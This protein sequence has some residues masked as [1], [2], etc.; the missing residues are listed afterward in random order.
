MF[1][2]ERVVEFLRVF[3]F[4]VVFCGTVC[5][6]EGGDGGGEARGKRG[7]EPS[8]GGPHWKTRKLGPAFRTLAQVESSRLLLS[9]PDSCAMRA[10]PHSEASAWHKDYAHSAYIFVKHLDQRLSEGDLITILSQFGTVTDVHMPRDKET[11]KTKGFAFA[12]Y[13]DQRSTVLAVDNF[14]KTKI[15]GKNILCDH[16]NDYKQEQQKDP[17]QIPQNLR[18]NLSQQQMEQ[19]KRQIS[20]RNEEITRQ[21]ELKAEIFSYA[22]GT[23]ETDDQRIEKEVRSE[24]IYAKEQEANCKRLAHFEKTQ[25]KH[26]MDMHQLNERVN[27]QDVSERLGRSVSPPNRPAGVPERR[28]DAASSRA[29]VGYEWG[30]RGGAVEVSDDSWSRFMGGGGKRKKFKTKLQG[31]GGEGE[32][33]K[34]QSEEGGGGLDEANT[35]RA[36]LGL[37]P[38]RQ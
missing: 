32:V 12:A 15:L 4:L 8:R 30:N 28:P 7:A 24:M 17:E 34:I 16:C 29:S 11:G 5:L 9:N 37:G 38:L 3:W 31:R 26:K 35:L 20:K 27:R 2:L 25:Q 18:R 19:R 10:L 22:R 14:N 23:A 1:V 6:V 21:A 33:E 36:R 13:Q